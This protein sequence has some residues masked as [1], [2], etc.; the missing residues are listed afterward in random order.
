MVEPLR[1]RTGV[2]VLFPSW[3]QHGVRPFSGD[4]ERVTVAL[5]LKA[6]RTEPAGG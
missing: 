2:L 3:L 1:P 4:G 5:N 6:V